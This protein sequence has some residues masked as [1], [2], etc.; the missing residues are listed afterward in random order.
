MC[1]RLHYLLRKKLQR[2]R[3]FGKIITTMLYNV[4]HNTELTREALSIKL[5]H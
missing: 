5:F 2:T 3:C 4:M 1:F